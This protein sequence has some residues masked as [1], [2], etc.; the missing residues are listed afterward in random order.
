MPV[1][2]PGVVLPQIDTRRRSMSCPAPNQFA[3]Y[4]KAMEWGR[5][6]RYFSVP[7][8]KVDEKA[9]RRRVHP[10]KF[11]VRLPSPSQSPPSPVS[12]PERRQQ[13]CLGGGRAVAQKSLKRS[14]GAV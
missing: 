3:D 13:V 8:A 7:F 12:S 11:K 5:M 9:A 4:A 14:Q 2:R 10:L 6:R 1:P